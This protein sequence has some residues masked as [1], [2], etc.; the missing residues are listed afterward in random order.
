M[1][2]VADLNSESHSA[3][4][5][6]SLHELEDGRVSLQTLEQAFGPESL[7]IIIVRDLPREFVELRRTLLSLSSY[8]ANLPQEELGM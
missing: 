2:S 7:G 3:A 8:L 6:V 4:V 1:G 5:S